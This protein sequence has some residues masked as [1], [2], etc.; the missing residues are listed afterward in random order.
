MAKDKKKTGK[1]ATQF[2]KD[3]QPKKRG[4]AAKTIILDA[5]RA[6]KKTEEEF[7]QAVAQKALFGGPDGDGDNQMMTLIAKKIAPDT[8]STF[9]TYE[10]KFPKDASKLQKADVIIDY[11]AKGT[12]PID[13][14]KMMI[15][16]IESAANIEEK[17]ELADRVAKLEEML[18]NA[19]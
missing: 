9:E 6:N 15:D 3:N 8:K 4:K 12:I 19:E 13:V 10:V 7:W 18:K 17:E 1:E 11:I 14:A 2:S 5:L 16:I